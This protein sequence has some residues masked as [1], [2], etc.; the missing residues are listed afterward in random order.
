MNTIDLLSIPQDLTIIILQQ[1]S[2]VDIA[3]LL[4]TSHD[5][6]IKITN[7]INAQN[8]YTNSPFLKDEY[9]IK[10]VQHLISYARAHNNILFKI[11]HVS[12]EMGLQ[13][14]ITSPHHQYLSHENKNCISLNIP[15][16]FGNNSEILQ[17]LVDKN[18]PLFDNLKCVKYNQSMYTVIETAIFG[19][20]HKLYVNYNMFKSRQL[21]E[22]VHL[23][24][25]YI[26]NSHCVKSVAM[27][28]NLHVLDI[29][30]CMRVRDVSALGRVHKLN[31]SYTR[32]R[33]VRALANVHELDIS[34]C[35]LITDVNVLTGVK[36]LICRNL[37]SYIS[38]HGLK[39]I[40]SLNLHNSRNILN[41]HS[42]GNNELLILGLIPS[43]SE[44]SIFKN[45]KVL[46]LSST[47]V[48]DVSML[49]DVY[50]LNL[51]HTKVSDVSALGRVHKLNLSNCYKINDF[52]ALGNVHTLILKS[53]SI[54]DVSPFS[55]V[56]TLDLS[57]TNVID[58]S[59]LVNVH[60]LSLFSS[61]KFYGIGLKNLESVRELN[62]ASTYIMDLNCINCTNLH[63]LNLTYCKYIRQFCTF[64][65][66][67]IHTLI[68]DDVDVPNIEDYKHIKNLSFKHKPNN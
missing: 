22:L 49:G 30:N 52:S 58:V 4:C 44:A 41:A 2:V 48:I 45:V 34:Y 24:E 60:N 17:L 39:N 50:D 27:L 12:I 38:V 65:N 10:T 32:V 62:L 51:S 33:D 9:E 68:L 21:R 13:T 5:I 66:T 23:R 54:T 59:P 55:R 56:H 61:Y 28:G 11:A 19:G 57:F 31:I 6:Q 29:S 7:I 36:K 46:D 20:V 53:T 67:H 42:L 47:S 18:K 35:N 1:L 26:P 14:Y 3:Q 16:Q 25:L 37:N 15:I 8:I 64:K 63:T 43:V 40:P